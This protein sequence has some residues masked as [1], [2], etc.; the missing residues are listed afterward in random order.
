[1]IRLLRLL[2]LALVSAVALAYLSAS[3]NWTSLI[4]MLGAVV[5]AFLIILLDIVIK[6]KDL[7]AL[8]GVLFGLLVGILVSLGLGYLIDQAARLLLGPPLYAEYELLIQG[9]RLLLSL[10]FCYV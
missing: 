2:F 3:S 10:M 4:I 5:L 7:G 9:A 1:M 8:S 6:H